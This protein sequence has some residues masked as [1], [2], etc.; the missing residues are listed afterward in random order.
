MKYHYFLL[1]TLLIT[2]CKK[3]YYQPPFINPDITSGLVINIP[4]DGTATELITNTN[5]VI[6]HTTLT[7]DHHGAANKAMHFSSI[8]SSFIDFGSLTNSS[9]TGNVFTV[10]CWV[11]VSDTLNPMAILS[12]RGLTGPWEYSLD[13]HFG[14]SHFNLDNWVSNG[15]TSVYG[16]DPLKASA[17][18]ALNSWMHLAYVANGTTLRVYL[19]GILQAGTDNYNTGLSFS[20]T[21]GNLIIGNG[22]GWE[23]NYYFNGDIDDIRMYNKALD[24]ATIQYLA[25]L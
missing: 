10:L 7:T 21:S 20:Q 12:K 13:N 16:A 23:R 25:A 8:D 3:D 14:K 4:F 24:A 1:L 2:A 19:N 11:R 22:G 9:F 17:N 15:G 18:I 6:N 5:G